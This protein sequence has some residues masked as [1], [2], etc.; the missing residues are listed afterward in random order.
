MFLT[1]CKFLDAEAEGFLKGKV[2]AKDSQDQ[3]LRTKSSLHK[4]DLLTP[5]GPK[6]RK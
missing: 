2:S 5:E 4:G 1:E 3:V 6:G